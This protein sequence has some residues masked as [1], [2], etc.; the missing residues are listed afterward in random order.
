M[1]RCVFLD[2]D[3]TIIRNDDHL[4]DPDGVEL[5][6]DVPAA[7]QDLHDAG[8]LM[9]VVTNQ[10]GVA[11]GI[12]TEQDVH[13]VHAMIRTRLREALGH[14]LLEH[15]YY[16]PWHPEGELKEFRGEHH[17]RKPGPGMLL[18]AAED[19][20]IDLEGSWM[21]GDQVRDI[22]AG[23]AAG[24]RTILLTMG[25]VT[26]MDD[27]QPEAIADSFAAAAKVILDTGA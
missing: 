24:C 23:Q 18:E 10:S 2:R 25:G 8:W 15:W 5:F 4:G 13:D 14:D 19:H 9:V 7:L 11:R 3:N 21:L 22:R 16:S 1:R 6:V 12:F 20:G 26:A 17:T 27:P